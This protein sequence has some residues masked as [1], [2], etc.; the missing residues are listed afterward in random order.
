MVLRPQVSRTEARHPLSAGLHALDPEAALTVLLDAQIA[1]LSAVRPA[2]PDIDRA[3]RVV[4]AAL[5]GTGRVIYAGAGSSGVM[6]LSDCLELAGTFGIPP[7]RTPMLLAGGT[8]TLL[9]MAGGVEDDETAAQADFDRIA[10]NQGDVLICLAASGRTPYTLAL[11][12][13]GR[14]AGVS[15]VGMANVRESPLLGIADIAILLDTGPEVVNGST[16]MG[17]ASAQ[18]VALN[19]LSVRVGLLL[20][21]VHDG[22]MVNVRADNAKLRNRAARIVAAIAGTGETAARAAL[23]ATDGAVKPAVLVAAGAAPDDAADILTRSG[24]VLGDALRHITTKTDKRE[25]A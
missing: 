25:K 20:G 6:A 23:S 15:V 14:A 9:D 19:M 8:A 4:A 13:L 12:R 7:E 5:R 17:A 10:P 21:H 22:Y 18:K 11:A 24:G 1:A 16:R 2:I 3:A